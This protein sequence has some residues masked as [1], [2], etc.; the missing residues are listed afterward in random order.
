MIVLR[1][2]DSTSSDP[3]NT[4]CLLLPLVVNRRKVAPVD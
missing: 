2:S 3:V 4:A 1:G